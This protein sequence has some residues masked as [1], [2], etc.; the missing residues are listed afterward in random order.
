MPYLKIVLIL[1]AVAVALA[2]TGGLIF[3]L[4]ARVTG[5]AAVTA[6]PTGWAILLFAWWAMSFLLGLRI[7][8]ALNI[9]P[10]SSPR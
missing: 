4:I 9:F 10:F 5:G 6:T 8:I 1:C 3:R 2:A 7:A